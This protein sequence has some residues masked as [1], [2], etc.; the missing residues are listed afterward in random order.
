MSLGKGTGRLV[1]AL[2]TGIVLAGVAQAQ[3]PIW[4]SRWDPGYDNWDEIRGMALAPDG[5]I[6]TTGFSQVSGYSFE[7]ATVK[8]T[9]D[10]GNVEWAR[11][12]HVLPNSR[13]EAK[14]MVV[15]GAGN[16]FV[17]GKS[18]TRSADSTDWIVL[19][20]LPDGSDGWQVRYH[21]VLIDVAMAVVADEAGGCYVAGYS[22]RAGANLDMYVVH[23]DSLGLVAWERRLNGVSGG[24]DA[25]NALVTDGL[26]HLYAAGYTWTGASDQNA[27]WLVK[28]DAATGDTLWS[29]TYNGLASTS[30]PRD[31]RALAAAVGPDGSVFVTGRAG[32]LG[33]WYDATVVGWDSTG[34]RLWVNRFDAGRNS[35]DGAGEI[36]V[37][38]AGNV[39]CGGYT[40]E[41][42]TDSDQDFLVF[43]VRPDGVLDWQQVYDAGVNEIDSCA[44]LA[45]DASGN[46]YAC[47]IVS[48]V[49]A[50]YDWMTVKY[51]GAGAQMW[52][53]VTGVYDEDDYANEILLDAL[54]DVYVGGMDL[55]EGG[56][57]FAL[58]KYSEN[59]VGAT[60]IL[61]PVDTLR[62]GATVSPRAWVRNYSA[63]A[64]TF[65]V[66]LYIGNFY[67]DAQTVTDIAPY[68]SVLVEFTPWLVRDVGDHRVLCFTAM[69]GDNEPGNDSVV[70][71]VTTVPA[72]E[73]LAPMPYSTVGRAREVKDGGAL[74]FTEDSLVFALKGNNTVEFYKYNID[75]DSWY[76]AETIPAYG[77]SGRKKRV[78]R[79]A[80]LAVDAGRHVYAVKG[81]NTDEFWRYSVDGES[82]WVSMSPVPLGAGRKVKGGTGLSYVPSVNR[83]YFS[84]GSN[85][86]EFFAYDVAADSW[87]A[88]AEVHPG[89]RDKKVKYGS[90]TVYDGDNT[91][92]LLKASYQ[93]FYAYSI[94]ADTWVTKPD[95]PYSPYGRKYKV[96]KGAGMVFD[97]VSER[98]YA[99]KG[100]KS[101]EWWY[102]DV[103]RDTWEQ[104]VQDSIPM[105]PSGKPPYY[106]SAM[107]MG[108]GKTYFLKGN[109]TLEFWRYNSDL[110]LNP[111]GGGLLDGTMTLASVPVLRRPEL[112]A[113]PNPFVGRAQLRFS[114]PRAGRARLVLYDVTGRVA[115]RLF[116]DER[117][118][119]DYRVALS[120]AGLARGVYLAQ[121]TLATP[122]GVMTAE[123]KVLVAR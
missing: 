91:I 74:A 115:L 30:D 75:R 99:A 120:S 56:E 80:R 112:A 108:D 22:S 86:R 84:K 57:D 63:V 68:D 31:D 90:C 51:S 79:G 49:N 110:P 92:Y 67:F 28:F 111:G 14:A 119:G 109:K 48:D 27:Y 102:F 81:N 94:S 7:F 15:D 70:T 35:E 37:D 25:A 1:V 95:M 60:A 78:K 116:D 11:G 42:Y 29:Q 16:S 82:S 19:K 58:L 54:G 107:T 17:V 122:E 6:V 87:S 59:D 24:N 33:T 55:Y 5:G 72:W 113:V 64:A 73:L 104:V 83:M 93:E 97:P 20:Y 77:P 26:G 69:P 13:D 96:K 71:M 2:L 123:E 89:P 114:L 100:G 18:D 39:F 10:S 62:T 32:E 47:G 9:A 66:W 46:V 36:V 105:G 40:Y 103:A 65:P 101:T 53:T 12:Y 23:Y 44:G 85:T 41:Y 121:L 21:Y 88:K 38:A 117:A 76:V 98:I 50:S 4:A 106:G 52:R 8:F 3:V 118:A 43:K 34:T 45:L 61:Q